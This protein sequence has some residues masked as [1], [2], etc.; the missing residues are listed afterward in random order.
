MA[1]T[2]SSTVAT[3]LA[4]YNDNLRWWESTTTAGN[5]LEAVLW[6]R[7]NR[8]RIAADAGTSFSFEPLSELQRKLEGFLGTGTT[9]NAQ[10]TNFT[11]ARPL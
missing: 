9:G 11:Q 10:R 6:L 8:A 5:L 3:A 4:Q 2:S 1:L 7:G